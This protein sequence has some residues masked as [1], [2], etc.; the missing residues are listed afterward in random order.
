[1]EV[2]F[3]ESFFESFKR[4]INRERWYWKIWD[5]VRYDAPRFFKNIWIFRKALWNYRW[6][7]G[8]HAILPLIQ[9]ALTDI[10]AKIEIRGIEETT[11]ANKKI[12]AMRRASEIMQHFIKDDFTELAEKELGE[13]VHHPWEFEPVPDKEGFVQLIDKDTP[14]EK[15][16][17]RKV[18]TRSRE[19]EESMWAELFHILKGQDFS[20]FE[21]APKDMK[22]ADQW[23]HWQKQFDGS[24]MRGWWD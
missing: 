6:W 7:S 20:K 21:E 23:D 22:H 5:F 17:N 10:S 18:F 24:G 8:H 19:I 3:G 1:M 14:E 16:H 15:E 4:M 13:I 12:A 2:N 11:S 9:T